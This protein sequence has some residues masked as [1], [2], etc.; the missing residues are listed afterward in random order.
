MI[1]QQC[2]SR[3]VPLVLCCRVLA[4]CYM[5][6]VPLIVTSLIFLPLHL[7]SY[8]NPQPSLGFPSG[9][10]ELSLMSTCAFQE[11]VDGGGVFHAGLFRRALSA[12]LNFL[13]CFLK[14]CF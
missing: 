9:R 10:H 11:L 5:L 1:A 13:K 6:V 7:L 8:P 3:M 14:S 4:F 12:A 2:L